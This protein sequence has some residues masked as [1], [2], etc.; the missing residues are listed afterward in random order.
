MTIA[1]QAREKRNAYIR[2]WRAKNKDKV[3]AYNDNYWLHKAEQEAEDGKME[4]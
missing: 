2:A 3:K 1:E 4:G